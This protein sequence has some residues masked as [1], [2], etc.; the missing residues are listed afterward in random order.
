MTSCTLH[1]LPSRDSVEYRSRRSWKSPWGSSPTARSPLRRIP[2]LRGRLSR[3]A[4]LPVIWLCARRS[5]EL[6]PEI[7]FTILARTLLRLGYFASVLADHLL[8]SQGDAEESARRINGAQ[9]APFYLR[10]G[11]RNRQPRRKRIGHPLSLRDVSV[12]IRPPDA[13]SILGLTQDLKEEAR[14]LDLPSTETSVVLCGKKQSPQSDSIR[15][16]DAKLPSVSLTPWEKD[17]GRTWFGG[18]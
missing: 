14:R 1:Q 10:P 8:L 15:F 9:C 4:G 11:W 13:T 2:F 3:I 17:P 5:N 6:I 18:S 16:L 7:F 12:Q